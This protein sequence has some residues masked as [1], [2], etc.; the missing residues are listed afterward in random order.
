MK[1]YFILSLLFLLSI[2]LFSQE[3]KICLGTFNNITKAENHVKLLEQKGIPATLQ[4]YNNEFKVLSLETLHSKEA[5][6]FQKEL[7]LNHPIIKQLNINEI[8]FVTSEEKTSSTK[9]NNSSSEELEILQKEL[10]SVKNKLQKTQNELQSTKTE[11]SKLRTQVQ[12]SQKKKVTS[13]AKPV[14]KIEETLPKERIIT[15]RD[16]DSGVPIPSADVNIDDTWNLKSNMVGQVL[17]PDEIQ[18]GEFT[19]SVKKGNEYVQTEDVFVVTKGEI[20]STPQISIPKAVDFKRIKII[21]DWGEFPW[22]LDAHV[23]DGENHVFFS[24]KKEGNLELDRDDV[25]SYGPET[26][27]IVE[28][29]EN[30]KYSYYVHDCSNT[31]INSSKR[32]S[33]SQAQVRVY[34]DNEYKTSFKI[35]PNKEGFTWHVFDIV[36]GDQI[37]P[38]EKIST[39]NPKDY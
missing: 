37:V 2:S 21:L 24:V 4:E 23:V 16:S 20:T 6:I 26:I 30:K 7:L 12:N 15:I 35:K 1:K 3:Y 33:N 17:L 9:L 39:K 27:T 14:Q 38:K 8:S 29:A 11:L 32:L 25:N 28:P 34:F 31:G 10:Q 22:D 19:I 5:A 18:E 13:P 36:K